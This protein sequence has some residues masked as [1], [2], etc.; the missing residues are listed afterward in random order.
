MEVDSTA[1]AASPLPQPPTL[2]SS[3]SS[4]ETQQP[5]SHER[6]NFRREL[7]ARSTDRSTVEDM[8]DMVVHRY[9]LAQKSKKKKSNSEI[10]NFY[11]KNQTFMKQGASSPKL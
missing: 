9:I 4:Q 8:A 5:S 11:G 6:S 3:S 1:M 2:P 7:Y 10:L